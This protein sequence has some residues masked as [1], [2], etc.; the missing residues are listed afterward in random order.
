MARFGPNYI[1]LR[2]N[3]NYMLIKDIG[4]WDMHQTV[5]NGAEQVVKE[6]VRRLDGRR[7]VYIDSE[8]ERDEIIITDDGKFAGF[9]VYS[10]A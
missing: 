4:P 8:G 7:L 2:D 3:P 1:I 10:R 9:R 5:T 6:L